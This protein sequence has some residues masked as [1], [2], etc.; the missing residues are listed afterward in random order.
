[1]REL[2]LIYM[3]GSKAHSGFPEVSYGKFASQLVA[4]GYRV[5]RIEQTETPEMLKE[6]NSKKGGKADKV[7]AIV[8]SYLKLALY[9]NYPIP[10]GQL[11]ALSIN[12]TPN[13]ITMPT[14]HFISPQ[15]GRREGDMLYHDKG[16]SYILPSRR[17]EHS[18]GL[19]KLLRLRGR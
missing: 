9:H 19:R 2:D 17:R 10:C 1:M 15:T 13:Q 14:T 4:K 11:I 16:N 3:K 7:I 5:A 8:V 6:R 18:R 12:L